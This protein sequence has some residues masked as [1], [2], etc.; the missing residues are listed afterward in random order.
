MSS[1]KRRD[2]PT[3]G[4]PTTATTLSVPQ[5]RSVEGIPELLQLRVPADE[6]RE[7]APRCGFE[8]GAGGVGSHQLEHLDRL[9][10]SLDRY[11]AE[12]GDL[13]E[14]F[15]QVQRLGGEQDAAG[16]RELLNARCQVRRLA[17]SRVVHAQIAADRAH[18][19]LSGVDADADLHLHALG[20]AKLLRIAAH[21]VL[22]PERRVA[23]SYGMI[24]LGER[25]AE[26]GHDAVAH[27][28]VHGALIVVDG[29][30]HAL[31]DGVEDLPGFLRV[32][33]GEQL[34]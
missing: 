28:L 10:E 17:H 23:R 16:R 29:V 8:A 22:H 12:L 31:D 21:D 11:R 14:G 9:T 30:H 2:L 26:E 33:I 18:H 7:A 1:Q 13:D 15:G 5:G 6:A 27:D 4:S 19:D 25:R 3:P 32:S 20:A 24:F 34:H